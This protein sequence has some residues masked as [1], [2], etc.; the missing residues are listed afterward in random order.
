MSGSAAWPALAWQARQTIRVRLTLWYVALL[1]LILLAFSGAVYIGLAR[2]LQAEADWRLTMAAQQTLAV[3]ELE[4]NR[5]DEPVS[6]EQL[7]TGTLMSVYNGRGQRLF[8]TDR[9]R[10]LPALSRDEVQAVVQG[11]WSVSTLQASDGVEWRLLTAPVLDSGRPSGAL[12]VARA[13]PEVAAALQQLQALLALAIPATLVVASAGG[14]FLAGRALGPI[15]RLTREAQAIG[16]DDLTRRLDP[17]PHEDEVGRLARTFNGMLDRLEQAFRRQRQFTADAAHELRTPLA[18]LASQVDVVLEWPRRATDYQEALANMREDISRM[19]AL[20]SE[21][22]TLA[23]A[24]AGQELLNRERLDLATLVDDVVT[25]MTPLAETGGVG[26][27][28]IS[29]ADIVVEGDQTRLTQLLI[30]LMDNAIKY[31]PAGGSVTVTARQHDAWAILEVADTGV[32]IEP[33]HLPY[34]F[35]R[36]YRA[37]PA[38]ARAAG[39]VGLGL[40]I[41]QWVVQAHGGTIAVASQPGRGTTVTVRLPL[42]AGPGAPGAVRDMTPVDET[43]MA[44]R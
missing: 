37:D 16:A 9:G 39:G 14:L 28:H 13:Q 10:L 1:A 15:D 27:T 33:E 23:R 38:R 8:S 29:G 18:M 3:V 20:L 36:F 44:V 5:L 43:H 30:N 40:A 26:L 11:P 32:G 25:A 34:L 12:Q 24:D 7:P 21:M 2:S 41:S 19:N 17:P 4:G 31:T 22:L 42:V 6:S 35:E